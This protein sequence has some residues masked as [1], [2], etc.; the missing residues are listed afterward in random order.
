MSVAN[1][2]VW[3]SQNLVRERQPLLQH[4]HKWSMRRSY[5]L[6]GLPGERQHEKVTRCYRH[7]DWGGI[8]HRSLYFNSERLLNSK[9]PVAPR[10]PHMQQVR[11]VK[12]QEV[13]V[14]L[15][16]WWEWGF[17]LH[18]GDR[19]HQRMPYDLNLILP[20]SIAT[21]HRE[22]RQLL[23]RYQCFTIA[24]V[25]LPK[26]PLQ[27]WNHLARVCQLNIGP[28]GFRQVDV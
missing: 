5:A 15:K 1:W 11:Y 8:Q 28:P 7:R 9:R 16:P 2:P 19:E 12:D 23:S 25:F 6:I 14:A 26:T 13:I 22:V 21:G 17:Y 3:R 24:W 20:R 18:F 10:D 27:R 4:H